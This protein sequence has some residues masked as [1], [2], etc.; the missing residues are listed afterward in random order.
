MSGLVGKYRRHVL[1]S[2]GSYK[3]WYFL[4]CFLAISCGNS[5][6][7]TI[8]LH[9]VWRK[10]K[11]TRLRSLNHLTYGLQNDQLWASAQSFKK[12]ARTLCDFKKSMSCGSPW[13]IAHKARVFKSHLCLENF[14]PP[15]T[16]LKSGHRSNLFINKNIIALWPLFKHV[17][18]GLRTSQDI[19]DFLK[20]VLLWATA[21]A[22]PRLIDLFKSPKVR[23]GF[24]NLARWQKLVIL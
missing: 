11:M 20:V 15:L 7:Q 10:N 24:L 14:S 2:R 1:S 22:N 5:Y 12:S 17:S 21:Q 3:I 6:W 4:D 8:R 18:R 9:K 19:V 23:A 13:A 16:Y